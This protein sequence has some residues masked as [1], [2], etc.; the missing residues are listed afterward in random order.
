MPGASEGCF[1][2]SAV[3]DAVVEDDK[4][5][6]IVLNFTDSALK[7]PTDTPVIT[8]LNNDGEISRHSIIS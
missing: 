4:V 5:F 7:P 1:E 8:I 6:T 3:E 2:V